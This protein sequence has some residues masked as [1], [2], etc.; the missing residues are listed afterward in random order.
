MR[1]LASSRRSAEASAK[2]AA[3]WVWR[4]DRRRAAGLYPSTPS[5]SFL[6]RGE[7]SDPAGRTSPLGPLQGDLASEA[8]EGASE[9]RL[10]GTLDAP[11]GL[12]AVGAVDGPVWRR[13]GVG[14]GVE[15]LLQQP[16][17]EVIDGL[18]GA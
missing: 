5:P 11:G 14:V 13:A 17:L 2:E 15:V 9:E 18:A 1:S 16:G 4:M 3:F 8:G 10:V 6:S 7:K 12:A